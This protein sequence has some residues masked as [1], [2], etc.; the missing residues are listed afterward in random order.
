MQHPGVTLDA[1]PTSHDRIAVTKD[2]E[3]AAALDSVAAIVPSGSKPATV[4]HDLAIRGAEALLEQHRADP[5]VIE[6]LIEQTTGEDL[7]FD[8]DVLADLD[9][10]AW[11]IEP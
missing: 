6:W 3:L 9:R 8:P 2:P 4:V 1:M 10:L 11:R 7:G 5:A